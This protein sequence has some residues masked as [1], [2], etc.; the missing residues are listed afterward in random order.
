MP[1][2]VLAER[3]AAVRRFNRFYTRNI[4]ILH[5]GLLGSPLSL[6]EGRVLYELAQRAPTTASA[7][8]LELTLDAGYLSQSQPLDEFTLAL[9]SIG[10]PIHGRPL[11]HIS[12][13]RVLGQ[14]FSIAESFEMEVQPQLLLLQKNMLMAEGVSRQLNPELNI[15]TLARPLIEQWMR[16]NRGPEARIK[17]AAEEVLHVSRR[18]PAVMR[19]LA[20]M[21]EP[22][23][24]FVRL[25]PR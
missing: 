11:Q 5:E 3:V 7:L 6:T 24:R 4:G 18:F 10:E 1:S 8:A 16:E 17:A 22:A 15:W 13:A 20:W 23:A 9:R 2:A 12:F 14:L 21:G 25:A 19:I